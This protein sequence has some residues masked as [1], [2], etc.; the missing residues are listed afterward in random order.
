MEKA[1]RSVERRRNQAIPKWG[2]TYIVGWRYDLVLHESVRVFRPDKSSVLS[3]HKNDDNSGVTIIENEIRSVLNQGVAN[4][5][6]AVNP[7]YT[8]VSPN[9][10]AIPETQRGQRILGDFTFN[11]R[12]AGAC[13]KVVL[14]GVVSY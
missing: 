14:R 9:V 11:A 2:A 12:L 3:K 6:I 13:H 5:G 8:V 10:L 7:T 1:Q 4:G